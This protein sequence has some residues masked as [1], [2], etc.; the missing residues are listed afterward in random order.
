MWWIVMTG[1]IALASLAGQ[2]LACLVRQIP[3]CNEDFDALSPFS[4]PV[5]RAQV[6]A[7]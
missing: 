5:C 7:R 4:S 2:R 6:R 1:G 3:D